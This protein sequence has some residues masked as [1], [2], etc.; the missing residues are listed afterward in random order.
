MRI[1]YHENLKWEKDATLFGTDHSWFT[2]ASYSH[3]FSGICMTTLLYIIMKHKSNAMILAIIIANVGRAIEDYLQ[4]ISINGKMYGIEGWFSKWAT[5][6][7]YKQFSE[8]DYDSLQN[9]IGDMLCFLVGSLISMYVL[10]HYTMIR[11]DYILF[12][13]V[14]FAFI[15]WFVMIGVYNCYVKHKF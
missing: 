10:R 12:I 5:C 6:K 2:N 9:Y 1:D 4:N 8:M 7:R 14:T 11:I 3:L 13:Y 15:V